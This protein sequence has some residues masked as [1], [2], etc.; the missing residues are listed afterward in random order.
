MY[1]VLIGWNEKLRLK[2]CDEI[3]VIFGWCLKFLIDL[4]KIVW[5]RIGEEKCLLKRLDGLFI[6]VFLFI[7]Y[8]L[9]LLFCL[10]DGRRGFICF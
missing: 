1:F 5:L 8:V 2:L 9:L 6:I 10:E 4:V 7:M 3:E